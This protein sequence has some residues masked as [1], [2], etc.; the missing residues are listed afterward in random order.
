MIDEDST[1]TN[2]L[3]T[4]AGQSV[5]NQIY[6]A[7]KAKIRAAKAVVSSGKFFSPAFYASL[8]HDST[9]QGFG[10]YL[11]LGTMI[12]M[13]GLQRSPEQTMGSNT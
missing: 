11:T 3:A 1:I 4:I 10:R 7:N 5:F 6:P 9:T 8:T 13:E 12:V 2:Y